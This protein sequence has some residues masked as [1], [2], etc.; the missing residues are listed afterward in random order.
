M[1][2]LA[3]SSDD[4]FDSRTQGE[5]KKL[6]LFGFEVNVYAKSAELHTGSEDDETAMNSPERAS[7]KME[8][9]YQCQFC[10]KEFVNS[11]ALGGHQNAHKKERLEKRRMQL[12]GRKGS[13]NFCFQPVK[14]DVGFIYHQSSFMF[15]D[16]ASPPIPEFM[17]YKE[18]QPQHHINFYGTQ[19]SSSL[20]SLPT[21]RT[22]QFLYKKAH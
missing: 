2:N 21:T 6:R 19:A 8:K 18:S 12:Q 11:Q 17:L 4:L 7:S 13:S 1:E 10:L 15:Y 22:F 5:D 20:P 14:S 16:S 3:A 9:K